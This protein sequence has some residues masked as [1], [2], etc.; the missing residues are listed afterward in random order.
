MPL[1]GLGK[2][3]MVIRLEVGIPAFLSDEERSLFIRFAKKA[4]LKFEKT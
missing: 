2:G 1:K 3:D 4:G